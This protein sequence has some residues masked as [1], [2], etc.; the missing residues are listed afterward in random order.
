MEIA[1]IENVQREDLNPMEEARAYTRLSE[2]F[3]LTQDQIAEKVGKSRPQVANTMRLQQLPQEIQEALIEKKISASN[4]RTLLSLPTDPERLALFHAML[5]NQFTV[6]QT[7]T[8]VAARRRSAMRDPNAEDVEDRLR[9]RLH[10][11]VQVKQTAKGT[12]EIR[13]KYFSPEELNAL[14]EKL[15]IT[16]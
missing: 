6:R 7:E 14:L 16:P 1:I 10:C 4:A 11:K 2:E 3:G 12:G 15:G 8:R 5:T 9:I 13:L